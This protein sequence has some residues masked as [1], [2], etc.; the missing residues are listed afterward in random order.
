MENA[1][2]VTVCVVAF[3]WFVVV[4]L[5]IDAW[6]QLV[7]NNSTELICNFSED[8]KMKK[9]RTIIG[10]TIKIDFFGRILG[11]KKKWQRIFYVGCAG[12]YEYKDEYFLINDGEL[13]EYS[14][15]FRT[16]KG[17]EIKPVIK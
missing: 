13:N 8:T 10:Y 15:N 14:F 9:S 17:I 2:L 12:Y 1:I 7:D 16:I 5:K 11:N 4:M 3:I 6:R